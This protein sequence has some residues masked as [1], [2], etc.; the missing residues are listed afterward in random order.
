MI[1]DFYINGGKDTKGRTLEEILN[2]SNLKFDIVHDF[3]QWIFPTNEQS[4]HNPDAP[5]LT[6]EEIGIL[7]GSEKAKNNMRKSLSRFMIFLG[8]EGHEDLNPYYYRVNWCYNKNHNLLRITR[9]IKSLKIFGLDE[10]AE[11]F[12]KKVVN[13][14]EENNVSNGTLLFWEDSLNNWNFS[15]NLDK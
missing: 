15:E 13:Y 14:V 4:L 10:E 12:H 5:V 7:R 8:I 9:V 11:D 1:I 2:Y 6:A 3:I